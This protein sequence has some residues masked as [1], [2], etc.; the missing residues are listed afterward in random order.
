MKQFGALSKVFRHDPGKHVI[1]V[2]SVAVLR[3]LLI[4]N[5]SPLFEVNGCNDNNYYMDVDN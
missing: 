1:L 5:G 2:E 4:E 3:Q